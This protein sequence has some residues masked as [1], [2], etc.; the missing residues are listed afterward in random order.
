MLGLLS[1]HH[2]PGRRAG[3]RI[4]SRR[5]DQPHGHSARVDGLG[6][7]RRAWA[8]WTILQPLGEEISQKRTLRKYWSRSRPAIPRKSLKK[9]F[10]WARVECNNAALE[11]LWPI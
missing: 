8:H 10:P 3:R 2:R 5:P 9:A 4:R 7:T 6:C 1:C 11:L